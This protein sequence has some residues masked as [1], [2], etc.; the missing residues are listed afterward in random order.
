MKNMLKPLL[1]LVLVLGVPA[2]A[3]ANDAATSARNEISQDVRQARQD[4]QDVKDDATMRRLQRQ[5]DNQTVG[6]YMGDAAVTAKVKSGM[7]GEKG[8]DSMDIKVITVDGTVTL[9]GD[10]DNRSQVG[11]AESVARQVEGVRNVDNKLV[12]KQ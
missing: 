10:V 5:E 3:A 12:V 1:A 9:M 6:E 8:L 2:F 11:L 4:I 7:L